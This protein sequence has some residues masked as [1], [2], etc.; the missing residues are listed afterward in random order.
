MQ[1]LRGAQSSLIAIFPHPRSPDLFIIILN[2][3]ILIT[4]ACA[5]GVVNFENTTVTIN[6]ELILLNYCLDCFQILH[7]N[8]L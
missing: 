2:V 5:C 8:I 7:L 1:I 3:V 4:S 6:Y